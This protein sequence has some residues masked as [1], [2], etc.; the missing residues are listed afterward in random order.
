MPL[1]VGRFA[2]SPT[3]ELHLGSLV[4]ALASYLDARAHGG[5]WIVRIEDLDPPR[6][7]VWAASNILRTLQVL[8]LSSDEKI[9]YQSNRHHLYQEALDSLIKTGFA[10]G[11]TCTRKQIAE[12][13]ASRGRP[14]N[15]YPG[16]CRGKNLTEGIR[17]WRFHVPSGER[18]FADRFFGEFSQDIEKEVGDFVL[19]RAD[20]F[21]A[22][23]L[24]V[25]VDD[26]KQG[27]THI[28]RGADLLDN[29]P[30]QIELQKAL[31]YR[32]PSYLHIP[33]VLGE[34]GQKLSKQNGAKG[35]DLQNIDKEIDK[36]WTHLGFPRFSYGSTKEFL[37]KATEFWAQS[38][39]FKRLD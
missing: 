37:S 19:K 9:V 14:Q 25:V 4:C 2:P 3:G 22:Y 16:T 34:N 36:A 10:Y 1:Y 32:V 21:W 12:Y 18:V 39:Y 30:R 27:V 17:S 15:I 11:C 6:E 7:P 38:P 31:G 29:T 8:G 24:A 5:K 26:E 23:Q 33:I 35:L 13:Q 20:G 28:V